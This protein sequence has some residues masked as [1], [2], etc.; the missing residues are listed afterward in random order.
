[1]VD[2]SFDPT[3]DELLFTVSLPTLNPTVPLPFSLVRDDLGVNLSADGPTLDVTVNGTL[4]FTFGATLIADIRPQLSTGTPSQGSAGPVIPID[5]QLTADATFTLTVNA[6][7][8]V[9][10]RV[11]Q[12][13]T[14]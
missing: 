6:S 4:Q 12:A 7:P 2:P 11:T 5:G 9:T 14:A 1:S 3:T 10:V 13:S 8:A